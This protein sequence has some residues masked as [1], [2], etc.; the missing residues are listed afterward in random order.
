MLLVPENEG[1]V[2]GGAVGRLVPFPGEGDLGTGLPAFLHHHVQ[3]LLLCPQ[4]AAVRVEAAAGDLH[5][6]GA[7]V[8]HLVEGHQQLMH[9]FFALQ[10]PLA[11]AQTAILA[12]E[13]AHVAE[14]EP[15]EWVE[16]V[17][18]G[19]E[20]E[21]VKVVRAVEEGG[22]G[23]VRVTVEIIAENFALVGQGHSTFKAWK[24]K[25]NQLN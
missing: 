7:A 24:D 18:L 10:P 4:T 12:R 8:H 3:H 14:G 22:E 2:G 11:P 17:V 21:E 15:P 1:D 23:G 13:P 19:I 9:H 5:V 6:L 20:V 25:K 16:E